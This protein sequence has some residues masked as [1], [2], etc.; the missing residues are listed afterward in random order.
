M[1]SA[2][3]WLQS[4]AWYCSGDTDTDA[5]SLE[6]VAHPVRPTIT[7]RPT[8]PIFFDIF[9]NLISVQREVGLQQRAELG[10]G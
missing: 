7:V 8:I 4:Q 1:Y 6:A 2:A 3:S 10:G 5:M 9:F